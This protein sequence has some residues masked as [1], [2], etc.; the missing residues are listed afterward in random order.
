MRCRFNPWVR[1][2]PWRRKWQP[3]P[4]F[5]P[6]EFHGQRS[7]VGYSPWGCKESDTTEWLTFTFQLSFRKCSIFISSSQLI[8]RIQRKWC[9]AN[10]ELSPSLAWK[11]PLS[12][13]NVLCWK[14][15]DMPLEKNQGPP[16]HWNSEFPVQPPDDSSLL[17]PNLMSHLI[18]CKAK[19]PLNYPT[20]WCNK[21]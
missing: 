1:K 8:S 14:S 10:S 4:V 17:G 6:G 12:S 11:L 21:L 15:D 13:W 19:E 18:P 20:L 7:L 9:C 5:L 16:G 2:I 3:T